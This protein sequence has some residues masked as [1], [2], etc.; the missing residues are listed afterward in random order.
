MNCI[1]DQ[2]QVEIHF[3]YMAQQVFCDLVPLSLQSSL[4]RHGTPH[5][6]LVLPRALF[7]TAPALALCCSRSIALLTTTAFPR[8]NSSLTRFLGV[9]SRSLLIKKSKALFTP[10]YSLPPSR[11]GDYCF[12]T[13]PDGKC[14]LGTDTLNSQCVEHDAW[15]TADISVKICCLN[16]GY[17]LKIS[18]NLNVCHTEI[19]IE[20]TE[21]Y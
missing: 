18:K 21:N 17:I 19:I 12:T 20:V 14:P 6:Y 9:V 16:S 15:P 11:L 5:S 2:I 13:L 7:P 4:C 8:L 1:F 3:L 10:W